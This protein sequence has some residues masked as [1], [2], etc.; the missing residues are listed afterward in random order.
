MDGKGCWHDNV[1]VERLW[2][3]AKY[4]EVYLRAYDSV[5]KAKAHLGAYLRFYNTCRPHRSLD[6]RTLD[7]IYFAA[8]P[9]QK[10]AA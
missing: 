10:A 7:T 2:K 4:E 3:S 9:Q 8:L 5:A 1:L 6:G